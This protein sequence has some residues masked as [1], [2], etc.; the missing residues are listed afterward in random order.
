MPRKLHT[1]SMKSL[2]ND[3]EVNARVTT[4]QVKK[5]EFA[6]TAHNPGLA[7]PSHRLLPPPEGNHSSQRT[8]LTSLLPGFYHPDMHPAHSGSVV[9]ILV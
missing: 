6:G 1:T 9:P 3:S 5:Q 4:T 2:A 8:R 7:L